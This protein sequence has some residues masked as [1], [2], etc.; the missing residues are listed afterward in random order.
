M[1]QSIDPDVHSPRRLQTSQDTEEHRRLDLQHQV[2]TI[3]LDGLFPA[4]NLVRRALSP[5][6]G[7][8]P[9]IL[10]VGTGSGSW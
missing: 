1:T 8:V 2:L 7:K 5:R 10:D 4:P 6:Q 9:A 3:A